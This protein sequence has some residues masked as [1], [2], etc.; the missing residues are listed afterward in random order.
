MFM[1]RLLFYTIEDDEEIGFEITIHILL[2]LQLVI[3]SIYLAAYIFTR[4]PLNLLHEKNNAQLKD[5][6]F[7]VRTYY[8]YLHNSI[9]FND[10]CNF[11][12]LNIIISIAMLNLN[13]K[14]SFLL[15]VQ[16]FTVIRFFKV[17][18]RIIESFGSRFRQLISMIC[19]L[20]IFILFYSN[21]GFFIYNDEFRSVDEEL[22]LDLGQKLIQTFM[23][24]FDFGQRS[25][26]GVGDKLEE[27]KYG[28]DKY[29]SRFRYD[30][31]YFIVVKLLILN[32]INGIV[33]SSFSDMR[34]TDDKKEEDQENRC[35]IC[36][37]SKKEFEKEEVDFKHHIKELHNI[38]DY[39]NFFIYLRDKNV[40][41]LNFYQSI[42]RENTMQKKIQIFPIGMTVDLKDYNISQEGGEED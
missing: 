42:V 41:D 4:Y 36:S 34:E 20:A 17:M 19:F 24:H 13:K 39:F 23:L 38:R 40:Y 5:A 32:M 37:I 35:F 33:V 1:I 16:L 25:G 22:K 7:I 9:L 18:Q 15:T 28:D 26:G 6:N 12:I 29:F 10:Y 21:I 14:F 3:N 2:I 8:V 11:I 31:I 27:V 30:M